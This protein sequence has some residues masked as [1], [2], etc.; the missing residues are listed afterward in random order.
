VLN[1]LTTSIASLVA[2]PL[3]GLTL[4]WLGLPTIVGLDALSFLVSAVCVTCVVVPAGT[5]SLTGPG[6]SPAQGAAPR[7]PVALPV[8]LLSRTWA[9]WREGL[10]TVGRDRR[11]GTL[12][13]LNGLVFAG[14]GI[15]AALFVV[16]LR[17][18]F[19]GGSV[20]LGWWLSGQGVGTLLAGLL[21]ARVRRTAV[22]H[23]AI[24]A[25]LLLRGALLVAQLLVPSLWAAIVC[26]SISTAGGV[27]Y[28]VGAQTLAQNVSADRYRGRV[29]GLLDSTTAV[30]LLAEMLLASAFGDAT[31]AV[32]LFAVT[33]LLWLVAGL[34]AW[35]GLGGAPARPGVAPTHRT[36]PAR[37]TQKGQ[38]LLH[39]GAR[40]VFSAMPA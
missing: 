27:V 21:A 15:T 39:G 23:R 37:E 5:L 30:S 11:L 40:P 33:A 28:T 12:I 3:G 2:A 31:G 38:S 18:R 8:A 32:P 6:A 35:R 20:E 36:R 26:A 25:A 4:A 7:P 22:P 14:M 1:G 29:F 13:G 24:A 17:E 19:G 16:F 34:I 9:D 10:Q